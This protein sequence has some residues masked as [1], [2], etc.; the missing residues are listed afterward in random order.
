M[1]VH[2]EYALYLGYHINMDDPLADLGKEV[3]V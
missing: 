2:L 3:D 1:A